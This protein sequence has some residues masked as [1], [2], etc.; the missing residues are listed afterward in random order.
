[1]RILCPDRGPA[2]CTHTPFSPQHVDRGSNTSTCSIFNFFPFLSLVHASKKQRVVNPMNL[3]HSS[4]GGGACEHESED[5]GPQERGL[6]SSEGGGP[7]DWVPSRPPHRGL[8]SARL[9]S[10]HRGYTGDSEAGPVQEAA[11]PPLL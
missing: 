8:L 9:Y 10:G 1:M 2:H 3:W 11:L 6:G 7:P 4:G 5:P